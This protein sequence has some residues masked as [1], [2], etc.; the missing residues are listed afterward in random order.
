MDQVLD[1]KRALKIFERRSVRLSD[2]GKI[3]AVVAF[4]GDK[5][6]F[7]LNRIKQFPLPTNISK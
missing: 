3:K 4:D 2:Q 5:V 6:E 7:G 1:N